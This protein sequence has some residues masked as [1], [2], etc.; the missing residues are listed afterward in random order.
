MYTGV[1]MFHLSMLSG[2]QLGPAAC[3]RDYSSHPQP[4]ASASAFTGKDR[5]PERGKGFCLAAQKSSLLTSTSLGVIQQLV[6]PTECSQYSKQVSSLSNFGAR[7]TE[8]L[9]SK[10]DG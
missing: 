9:S 3:N 4:Y 6:Y 10:C 8:E 7:N 1:A 5:L 2:L